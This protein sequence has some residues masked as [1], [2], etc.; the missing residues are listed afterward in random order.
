MSDSNKLEHTLMPIPKK[1]T[2]PGAET[3]SQ[4]NVQKNTRFVVTDESNRLLCL[5]GFGNGVIFVCN[6]KASSFSTLAVATEFIEKCNET[7][8]AFFPNPLKLKVVELIHD[9]NFNADEGI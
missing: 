6:G 4:R 3:H 5:Q 8:D 2:T 7:M 1:K 9:D